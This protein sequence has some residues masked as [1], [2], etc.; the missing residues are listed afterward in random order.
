MISADK[1]SC[2][3]ITTGDAAVPRTAAALGKE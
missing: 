2:I 1:P 3:A